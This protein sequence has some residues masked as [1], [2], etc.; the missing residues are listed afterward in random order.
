MNRDN[1]HAAVEHA[2]ALVDA[3]QAQ[4]AREIAIGVLQATAALM[5]ACLQARALACLA[6]AEA[7]HS[8]FRAACDTSLRAAQLFRQ[9]GDAGGEC[10]ALV[11]HARAAGRLGRNQEAVDAAWTSARLA[12]SLPRGSLQAIA[13]NELGVA[14]AFSRGF[15]RAESAFETS[16]RLAQDCEPAHSAFQPRHNRAWAEAWRLALERAGTG[17]LPPLARLRTLIDACELVSMDGEP[18]CLEPDARAETLAS[19]PLLRALCACWEG[20]AAAAADGLAC[21][22]LVRESEGIPR[23][24]GALERWVQVEMAQSRDDASGAHDAADAMVCIASICG[25]EQLAGL[26]LLLKGRLHETQGRP[27][28]SLAQLRLLRRRED[29]ILA[30]GMDSRARMVQGRIDGHG[31]DTPHRTAVG[32]GVPDETA[33]GEAALCGLATRNEFHACL[34]ERA[35]T[36]SRSLGTRRSPGFTLIELLVVMAALGLL[37]ALTAPRYVEHVDRARE[38]VLR[39]NLVGTRDAIDKFYADRARYP[40]DLQE[41]V[42]EHYLRRLP[43]DPVTGRDDTWVLVPPRGQEAGSAVYDLRSGATGSSRD[44]VAYATW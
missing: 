18:R 1:L 40:K 7:I 10:G 21:L 42:T 14:C 35:R 16:A 37:L 5:D 15:D 34:R 25:H 17:R 32:D 23:W 24:V 27:R 3:G 33:R 4:E 28:E 44:G 2:T 20:D 13:W 36:S 39:Q 19:W 22:A 30:E 9:R 41:L 11:M 38:A 31:I 26:G 43:L 29:A 12:G 8:R 6:R